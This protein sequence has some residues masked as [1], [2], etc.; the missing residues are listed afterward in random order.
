[1]TPS[2][3]TLSRQ[4]NSTRNSKRKLLYQSQVHMYIFQVYIYTGCPKAKYKN[5]KD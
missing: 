1:V 5:A 4:L 2:F 3:I